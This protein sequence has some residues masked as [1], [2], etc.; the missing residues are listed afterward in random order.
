L[1]TKK[2]GGGFLN[3]LEK[4]KFSLITLLINPIK[5]PIPNF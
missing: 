2:Q 3:K 1:L 4:S 5:D